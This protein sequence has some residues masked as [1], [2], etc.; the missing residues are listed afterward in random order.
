MNGN[1]ALHHVCKRLC[2]LPAPRFAIGQD[3]ENRSVSRAA[4]QFLVLL[5]DSQ[6]PCDPQFEIGV[7]RRVVLDSKGWL[8]VKVVE[9]EKQRVGI[10]REANLWRSNVREHGHRDAVLT[11]AQRV[12]QLTQEPHRTLPA[13]AHRSTAGSVDPLHVAD[14]HGCR[15]IL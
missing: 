6:S 5:D 10:A 11:P 15:C 2:D 3:N 4:A 1:T 12:A 8:R 7:P 14:P 13:I 9:E